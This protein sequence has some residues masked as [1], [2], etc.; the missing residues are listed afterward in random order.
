MSIYPYKHMY[1]YHIYM[2]TFKK[3]SRFNFEIH[4]VGHKNAS[5][6]METSPPTGCHDLA[7]LS[8]KKNFELINL[9]S[10]FVEYF[11]KS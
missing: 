3:L 6:L 9:A 1:A 11:S 8:N 10:F 4:E 7:S 5:L 2:C